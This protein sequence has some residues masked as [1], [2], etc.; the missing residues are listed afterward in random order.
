MLH[1]PRFFIEIGRNYNGEKYRKFL[2]IWTK[3]REEN[4]RTGEKM[5]GYI[6]STANLIRLGW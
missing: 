3:L 2:T 1:K 5:C 4:L 6:I